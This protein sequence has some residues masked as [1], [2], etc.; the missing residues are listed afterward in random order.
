MKMGELIFRAWYYLR[1]GYGTYMS[2]IVGF[3]TFVSTT[4][5]LAV[6]RMPLLKEVFS[7]FYMYVI[8]SL[9]LIVS[10]CVFLGWLHMKRTLAYPTQVRIN[11]EAN[12]YNYIRIPG[13]ETE[14]IW[15][16]WSVLLQTFQRFLEKENV[17]TEEE[18]KEFENVINKIEILRKGG[19]I[20]TPR[21]RQLSKKVDQ[22]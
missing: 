16:L 18:K 8:V 20:G 10:F 4:Y 5:Y 13:K 11:V 15:P 9:M 12:P 21:Q 7:H 22:G 17:M 14:I 3:V 1:L 6:E 2:F 19:V